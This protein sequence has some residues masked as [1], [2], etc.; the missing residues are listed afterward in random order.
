M[1]EAAWAFPL[2]GLVLALIAGGLGS[3]AIWAGLSPALSA[4]VI[5]ASFT[6]T[7]G[8][9]HEDGLADTADGFWGGWDKA[10]RLDIMKDSHIG[11]YGVLA[12]IISF[13]ARWAAL[14]ALI[15]QEDWL[16]PLIATACLSR[17]TMPVLLQTRPNARQTGLSH[18]TG[19]PER[20]TVMLGIG[21][22]AL[23][24]LICT[25][26]TAVTLAMIAA[27]STILMATLAR[28][29]IGGQTGDVL[30][31]TQQITEIALLATLTL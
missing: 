9:M 18:H 8:A 26:S 22:A 28:A 1:A 24:A 7:T 15:S 25:G 12:L 20:S 29:K 4:I 17:A 13:A 23:I 6:F 27:L 31:A 3:I 30:G 21:L 16:G 11:T 14:T 19:R 2:V 5:L 10:K